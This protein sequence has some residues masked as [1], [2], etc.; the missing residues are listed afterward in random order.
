MSRYRKD[1]YY[2][3]AE[4]S[5]K[6]LQQMAVASVRGLEKVYEIC[7]FHC[8]RFTLSCRQRCISVSC[9]WSP[10]SVPN[11]ISSLLRC[12]VGNTKQI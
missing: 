8:H 5:S 9:D 7:K 11:G 1:A 6:A 10:I 12:T 3:K 4:S 2:H